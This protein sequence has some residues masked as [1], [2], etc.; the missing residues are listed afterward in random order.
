MSLIRVLYKGIQD[1]CVRQLKAYVEHY[2]NEAEKKQA[3]EHYI[4]ERMSSSDGLVV[5]AIDSEGNQKKVLLVLKNNTI[6]KS[7][8]NKDANTMQKFINFCKSK[9]YPKDALNLHIRKHEYFEKI[10]VIN[11]SI[12]GSD[13]KGHITYFYKK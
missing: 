4:I 2:A 3:I 11:F 13:F 6:F 5:D 10:D 12:T 9:K 8:L 1:Q 7:N